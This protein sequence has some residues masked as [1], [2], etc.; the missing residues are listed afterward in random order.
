MMQIP[1]FIFGIGLPTLSGVLFLALL[2]KNHPVLA[3]TERLA[4]GFILGMAY[5]MF[6]TFLIH[7][8]TGI[9]LALPLFLGI[10]IITLGILL[11]LAHKDKKEILEIIFNFQFSIFNYLAITS[12]VYTMLL[13]CHAVREQFSAYSVQIPSV[14]RRDSASEPCVFS[15]RI[16]WGSRIRITRRI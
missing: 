15:S 9:A 14:P 5:T 8:T 10:Q 11:G 16:S 1:A 4:L 3:R 2:E 13:L 12:F 7:V 6:L